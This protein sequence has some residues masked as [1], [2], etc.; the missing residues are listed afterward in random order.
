MLSDTEMA[1][2]PRDLDVVELWSGVQAIVNAA[3]KMGKKAMPFDIARIP[4]KTTYSEDICSERPRYLQ[5]FFA[6]HSQSC[7]AQV[8]CSTCV[9]HVGLRCCRVPQCGGTGHEDTSWGIALDGDCVLVVRVRK[10]FEHPEKF[11]AA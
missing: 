3:V 6:L 2:L 10:F 9:P 8:L 11:G 5:A 1:S 4:G 7:S